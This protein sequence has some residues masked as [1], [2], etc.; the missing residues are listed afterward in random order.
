MAVKREVNPPATTSA[1]VL[2]TA[3]EWKARGE[4]IL[5]V[6]LRAVQVWPMSVD[7]HTSEKKAVAFIPPTT[8]TTDTH[9]AP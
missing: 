5:P 4:N 8:Y 3:S 2:A 7:H 6:E 9:T 1:P